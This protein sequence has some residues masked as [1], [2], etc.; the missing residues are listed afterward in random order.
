MVVL[1]EN[2]I[3]RRTLVMDNAAIH[4]SAEVQEAV[5]KQ[6]FEIMYLPPYSPFLNLIEEYWS[7]LKA[8]VKCH[9]LTSDDTLLLKIIDSANQVTA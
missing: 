3:D 2:G 6:G 5:V 1:K 9:L 8:G 4:K 7:K